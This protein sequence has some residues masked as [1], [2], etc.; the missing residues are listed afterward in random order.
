MQSEIARLIP[1]SLQAPGQAARRLLAL[2]VP[3]NVVWLG[4]GLVVVLG[5]GLSYLT[6]AILALSGG[7]PSGPTAQV[8][9][10]GF[11]IIQAVSTLVLA[12][13][14]TFGGRIFGGKGSF[15]QGLLLAVWIEFLLAILQG[16]QFV[17]AIFAP[18]LALMLGFA[19]VAIFLW[20]LT[21]F[22]AALHGFASL[23]K[24]FGGVTGGFLLAGFVLF[25]ILGPEFA[26]VGS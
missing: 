17:V 21:H 24:T 11:A 19:A 25:L 26:T 6:T 10:M 9:P 13:A 5:A 18:P 22:V 2:N 7:Q 8:S 1:L 23:G 20:V 14:A 4:F 3:M 16:L 15:G 12:A